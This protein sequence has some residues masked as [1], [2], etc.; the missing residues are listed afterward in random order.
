MPGVWL[1]HPKHWSNVE[2]KN[3]GVLLGVQEH[4]VS[5]VRTHWIF[6]ED[7]KSNRLQR[8]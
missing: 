4:K 7:I 6:L 1:Y 5:I 3:Q 2:I 8:L